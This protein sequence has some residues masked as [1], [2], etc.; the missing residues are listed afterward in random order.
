MSGALL[1]TPAFWC[2]VPNKYS[3]ACVISLL[4][5]LTFV[6]DCSK[7]VDDKI[8]EIGESRHWSRVQD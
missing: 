5:A 3:R 4:Q 6:I 7:P 1:Q 8:M 2:M